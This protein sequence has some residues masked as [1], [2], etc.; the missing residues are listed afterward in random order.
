ML[1]K[2]LPQFKCEM[3]DYLLYL[4]GGSN[5]LGVALHATQERKVDERHNWRPHNLVRRGLGQH[6]LER[7]RVVRHDLAVENSIPARAR[8]PSEHTNKQRC[9]RALYRT[10]ATS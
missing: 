1:G 3:M 6:G 10:M 9:Q 7:L 8:E 5:E 2:T 4:D